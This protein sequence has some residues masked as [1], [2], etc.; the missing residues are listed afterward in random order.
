MACK[1]ARRC[2]CVLCMLAMAR[3]LQVCLHGWLLPVRSGRMMALL[4]RGQLAVLHCTCQP[5]TPAAAAACATCRKGSEHHGACCCRPMVAGPQHA[6]CMRLQ[7]AKA[8]DGIVYKPHMLRWRQP[9]TAR[10]TL[11]GA[12]GRY[13][14]VSCCHDADSYDTLWLGVTLSQHGQV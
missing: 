13:R 10:G 5:A 3:A 1:L 14:R 7:P 6:C 4:L 11:H 9:L 8:G 12:T 2:W